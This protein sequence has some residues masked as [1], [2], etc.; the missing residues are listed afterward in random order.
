MAHI[1]VEYTITV[2]LFDLE[3]SHTQSRVEVEK[4]LKEIGQTKLRAWLAGNAFDPQGKVFVENIRIITK[5]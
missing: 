3:T 5:P 2:N 4:K 1:D